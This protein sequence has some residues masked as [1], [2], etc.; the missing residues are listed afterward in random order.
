MLLD[1]EIK[2]DSTKLIIMLSSIMEFTTNLST[3]V[4][5]AM[6]HQKMEEKMTAVSSFFRDTVQEHTL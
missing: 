5:M 3:A 1:A 4:R 6:R 2:I